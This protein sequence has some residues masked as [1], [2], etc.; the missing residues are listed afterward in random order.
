[1]FKSELR[2]YLVICQSDNPFGLRTKSDLFY[3]VTHCKLEQL[4]DPGV[5]R[6]KN[7]PP[8]LHIYLW[9]H[10]TLTFDLLHPS[11]WAFTVVCPSQFS[12]LKFVGEFLI[13][14]AKFEIVTYFGLVWPWPV[15]S[16]P[17][18]STFLP[19]APEITC[20][21]LHKTV[22]DK[23]QQNSWHELM[24]LLVLLMIL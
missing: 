23:V 5:K 7:D 14:L 18:K 19:L 8:G 20:A 21:N 1:M 10:M 12:F 15:P 9:P 11:C 2:S 6:L 17:P 3:Q 24:W 13:N 4:L 16:W 22:L